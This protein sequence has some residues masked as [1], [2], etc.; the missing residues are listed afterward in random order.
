MDHPLTLYHRRK[1][2]KYNRHQ[3]KIEKSSISH[4]SSKL[5]NKSM[6]YCKIMLFALFFT[7]CSNSSDKG[8]V[9]TNATDGKLYKIPNSQNGDVIIAIDSNGGLISVTNSVGAFKQVIS[10]HEHSGY[11]MG[12]ALIDSSS[13]QQR[14]AYFFNEND[15]RLHSTYEYRNG[16]RTGDGFSF[17]DG[18]NAVNQYTVFDS[19]GNVS[20]RRTYDSFGNHILTEGRSSE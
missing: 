3:F 7:C 9:I 4:S 2:P 13:V 14:V 20:F 19:T 18:M 8:V 12:K 1:N 11:V 15:E 17:H 10:Y 6:N 16:I 5:N